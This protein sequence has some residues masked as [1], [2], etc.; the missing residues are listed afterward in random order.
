[1]EM[2]MVIHFPI[3]KTAEV[4]LAFCVSHQRF[5]K[6]KKVSVNVL[7]TPQLN[8]D[9]L[10][11]VRLRARNYC[12]IAVRFDYSYRAKGIPSSNYPDI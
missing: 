12:T 1:M 11:T 6:Q 3:S 4:A 8:K 5:W 2:E 7:T 9:P 10:V